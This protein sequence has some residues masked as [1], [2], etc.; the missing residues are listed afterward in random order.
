MTQN[1][2]LERHIISFAFSYTLRLHTLTCGKH[3]IYNKVV[4]RY[5]YLQ[6]GKVYLVKT[7]YT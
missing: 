6:G 7:V 3:G 2:R 4:A 5:M 1:L